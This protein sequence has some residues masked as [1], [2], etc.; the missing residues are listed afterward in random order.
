MEQNVLRMLDSMIATSDDPEVIDMLEHHKRQTQTHAYRMRERLE[1]HGATPSVVRQAGGILQALAKL[2]LDMV[3]GEKAGRNARDGYATE[4][5]E[6]ASYELLSRIADR[7][8]DEQTAVAAREIIADEREMADF[9]SANWDLFAAAS[10]RE[11]GIPVRPDLAHPGP[12]A[13]PAALLLEPG[14]EEALDLATAAR[15]LEPR[16]HELPLHDDECRHGLDAETFD[17][18]GALDL[19]DAIEPERAVVAAALQYLRQESLHTAAVARDGR[20]EKDEPGLGGHHR[21]LRDAHAGTSCVS[22]VEPVARAGSG[23]ELGETYPRAQRSLTWP[24]SRTAHR[25]S[26]IR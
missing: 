20:V 2:P 13:R 18:V 14:S 11:A 25:R 15:P 3:R 19:V 10:L 8:G 17:Q 9:I 22:G 23:P 5:L 4:H 12:A 7:A 21:A 16:P 24:G 1:A 26:R 6:I